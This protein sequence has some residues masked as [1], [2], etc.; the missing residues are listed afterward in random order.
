MSRALQRTKVGLADRGSGPPP[1]AADSLPRATATRLFWHGR[2][3]GSQW[4]SSRPPSSTR[5]RAARPTACPSSWSSRTC[6]KSS[7]PSRCRS[8]CTMSPRTSWRRGTRASS[9]SWTTSTSRRRCSPAPCSS[10]SAFESRKCP[11]AKTGSV[12]ASGS[13]RTTPSARRTSV[14]SRAASPTRSASSASGR[15]TPTAPA[16][17]RAEEMLQA[18]HARGGGPTSGLVRARRRPRDNASALTS[19][20]TRRCRCS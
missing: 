19:R 5:T 17:P 2:A 16:W 4:W 7:S 15:A 10:R 1:T 13:T 18:A 14:P 12:S 9:T 6:A 11:G 8:G 3:P 20:P